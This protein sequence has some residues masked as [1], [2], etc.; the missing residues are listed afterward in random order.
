MCFRMNCPKYDGKTYCV[1]E[2]YCPMHDSWW[3]KVIQWLKGY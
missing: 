3:R 1:R 2:V